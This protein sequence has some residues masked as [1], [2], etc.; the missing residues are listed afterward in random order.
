MNDIRPL[1]LKVLGIAKVF[2]GICV[3]NQIPYYLGGG[4]LLGAIRHKGFIPWDDDLDFLVPREYYKSL[5]TILKKEL[6]GNLDIKTSET[7]DKIWGEIVKIEDSSVLVKETIGNSV[8]EH[9]AFIDIFPLDYTD[10]SKKVF[11]KN[12]MIR[13]LLMAE[14]IK[15]SGANSL[16]VK[17]IKTFPCVFGKSFYIKLV[18]SLVARHG[19]FQT[20]Y[21]G[22]YGERETVPSFY[23]GA[24]TLYDFEDTKFY[25]IERYDLY[26]E[27]D[28]GDYM[29][30]PSEEN[31]RTHIQDFWMVD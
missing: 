22:A 3:E 24:P 15:R 28:Y 16:K 31:R 10:D 19:E 30:L 27:H 26:L 20:S 29:R 17:I 23:W 8:F 25:G 7:D 13:K 9:G 4:G 18:R 11:S 5:I 1:Q 6:T 21:W 14:A 12:W 2:H